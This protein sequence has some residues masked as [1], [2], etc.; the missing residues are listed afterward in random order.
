MF[1][2]R[3]MILPFQSPEGD[4]ILVNAPTTDDDPTGQ[5]KPAATLTAKEKLDGAF[6]MAAQIAAKTDSRN[7]ISWRITLALWAALAAAAVAFRVEQMPIWIGPAILIVYGNWLNNIFLRHEQD[8]HIFW[9][10]LKQAQILMR[11]SGMPVPPMDSRL[12]IGR[13]HLWMP[14]PFKFLSEWALRTQFLV[15]LGLISADYF[16]CANSVSWLHFGKLATAS[17][18]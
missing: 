4:E 1:D 6:R 16:M 18:H 12:Q 14:R 2:L 7:Q 11:Q 10:F 15:T 17:M 13:S 8:S 3:S 9:P 5:A